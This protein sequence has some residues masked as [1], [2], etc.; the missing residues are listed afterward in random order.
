MP[1]L[2]AAIHQPKLL[3]GEGIEEVRFFTALLQHLGL[4]D[5]QVEQY[6]GKNKLSAYLRTLPQR[7]GY[8]NLAALAITRDADEVAG[9]AFQSFCNALRSANFDA[10][11][12]HDE[13]TA[14]SPRVGI[15]ILSDGKNPGMLEDLCLAALHVDPAMACVEEYFQ[16]LQQQQLPIPENIS[17]AKLHAWL[18]SRKLPDKRVGEAAVS[19]YF[20]WD[21]AAFALLKK[22]LV[23][24]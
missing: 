10:P 24:L 18:S 20:N 23:E 5:I 22:I 15:F 21:D 11:K 2:P 14:P 19:G 4:S 7:V 6:G 3:I 1:E 13:F 17:K 8:Q 12:R 9:Q 16:C